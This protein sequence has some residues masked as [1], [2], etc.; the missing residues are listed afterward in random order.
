M[1]SPA[2]CLPMSSQIAVFLL[3]TA[4]V[5]CTSSGEFYHFLRRQFVIF[6]LNAGLPVL[7]LKLF[8]DREINA[9]YLFRRGRSYIAYR[10]ET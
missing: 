4:A 3:I 10:A 2:G 6:F 8:L 7:K 1:A 5:F 9:N